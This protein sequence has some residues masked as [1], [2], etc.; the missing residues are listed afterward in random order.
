M[1]NENS[2]RNSNFNPNDPTIVI[3][4]G[5]IS[6]RDSEPNPT[7]RSGKEQFSKLVQ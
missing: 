4:H 3:V 6:S 7:V 1:N 2:V 5:W